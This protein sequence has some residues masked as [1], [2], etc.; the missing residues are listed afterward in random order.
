MFSSSRNFHIE[1]ASEKEA[2]EWVELIR[3][4]ARIDEEDE[5]MIL[6]SPSMAR[7]LATPFGVRER[8]A[9]I[10]GSSSEEQEGFTGIHTGSRSVSGPGNLHSARRPSNTVTNFSGNEQGSFSDLSDPGFPDSVTSLSN[11]PGIVAKVPG[12]NTI[13]GAPT[14]PAAKRN[15]SHMSAL[16]KSNPPP[17][18]RVVFHGWLYLLKTHG[19]VKQWRS[20]WAVVRPKTFAIYKNEEVCTL[21]SSRNVLTDID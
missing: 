21:L 12:E 14:R 15:V 20:V 1:T 2:Q 9:T 6:M 11:E 13:Y 8:G 3:R 5:E 18:E 19:G 4:E 10:G 7:E 17:E 16:N